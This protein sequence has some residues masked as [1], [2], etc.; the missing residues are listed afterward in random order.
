MA[1]HP[2]VVADDLQGVAVAGHDDRRDAVP[3]RLG[4]Q[5]AEDVVGLVAGQHEIVDTEGREHLR[6]VRP[7]HRER[8]GHVRTMG[9]V[10][11]VLLVAEGLLARVPGDGQCRRL[12]LGDELEQHLAESL[13]SV[14]RKAVAT[15]DRLGQGEVSAEGEAAAVD[16]DQPRLTSASVMAGF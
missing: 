10:V 8:L 2:D 6:Q 14:G 13:Q 11:L 7:L 4:G 12:V 3:S 9:L 16:E 15:G 1:H 5:R